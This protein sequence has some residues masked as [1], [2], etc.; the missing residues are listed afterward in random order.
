MH[1]K[2]TINGFAFRTS[3][4]PTGTGEHVL[5]VNKRMLTGANTGVGAVAR[6]RIEPDTEKHDV[7]VPPELARA[8][9]EDRAVRRWFDALNGSMRKFVVSGVAGLKSAEARER[10]AGQTAEWL[11]ETMEAERELPPML[12]TAFAR[13][14]QAHEGWKR[15]SPL[16]RRTHL[17]GIFYYRSAEARIRR[18]TRMLKE[19]HA[20]AEKR[21]SHE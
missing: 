1:V 7:L 15:M 12:R 9:N 18:M 14:P 17:L 11:L 10:R 13:Y 3:L 20:I 2:G 8:L 19:A 16:R 4:F 6:F 5:L 21:D